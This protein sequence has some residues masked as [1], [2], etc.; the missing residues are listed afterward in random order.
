MPVATRART[1][2]ASTCKPF[3]ALGSRARRTLALT[4]GG[5]LVAPIWSAARRMIRR[6][7]TA[8]MMRAARR[9]CKAGLESRLDALCQG[10]STLD[11]VTGGAMHAFK[12]IGCQQRDEREA[13]GRIQKPAKPD[14]ARRSSNDLDDPRGYRDRRRHHAL[15]VT[16]V[17]TRA[18]ICS[19]AV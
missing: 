7:G 15:D 18:T 1:L 14:G 4:A 2:G 11:A 16:R 5:G 6:L 3:P 19:V 9:N 10:R 17:K 13:F 12:D 8:G